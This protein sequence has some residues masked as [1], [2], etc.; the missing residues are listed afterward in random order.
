MTG[1]GVAN[2][3]TRRFFY[4]DERK[5]DGSGAGTDLGAESHAKFYLKLAEGD[6]ERL[7][8]DPTFVD[9]EYKKF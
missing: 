5:E 6:V 2:V 7:P 3:L 4:A 9:G 1:E 8:F